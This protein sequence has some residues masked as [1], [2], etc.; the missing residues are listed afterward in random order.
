MMEFCFGFWYTVLREHEYDGSCLGL[1]T[2][3]FDYLPSITSVPMTA[4]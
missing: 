1:N 2:H 3:I 4:P